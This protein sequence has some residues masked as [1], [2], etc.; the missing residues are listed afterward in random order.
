MSLAQ[1][2]HFQTSLD[3]NAI[4]YE[5]QSMKN[6]TPLNFRYTNKQFCPFQKFVDHRPNPYRPLSKTNSDVNFFNHPIEKEKYISCYKFVNNR[7]LYPLVTRSDLA[8]YLKLDGTLLRHQTPCNSCN[9]INGGNYGRNYYSLIKKSFPFIKGN[10]C[11]NLTKFIP[12]Y[13]TPSNSRNLTNRFKKK[14]LRNSHDDYFNSNINNK[15][16][17]YSTEEKNIRSKSVI[18]KIYEKN[19]KEEKKNEE[20]NDFNLTKFLKNN[21]NQRFKYLS[22]NSQSNYFYRP[23]IRKSFHKTQIF[24]HAKPFLVDEFKEY[25]GYK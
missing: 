23:V 21:D 13:N 15:N 24:N 11:G 16:N 12:R 19:K 3:N 5:I 14:F 9:K 25:G 18:K 6:R 22:R 20:D 2:A 10:F 1:N 17:N 7:R 4:K 8:K